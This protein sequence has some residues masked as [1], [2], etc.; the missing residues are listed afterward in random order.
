MNTVNNTSLSLMVS[1][2]VPVMTEATGKGRAILKQ[3]GIGMDWEL[4]ISTVLGV[5]I[6]R[7]LYDLIKKDKEDDK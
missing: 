4:F 1:V 7:A 3:R 5:I 6:G 2:V